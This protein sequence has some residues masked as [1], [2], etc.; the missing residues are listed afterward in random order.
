MSILIKGMA[1]PKNC[2]ECRFSA[3]GYCTAKSINFLDWS[4]VDDQPKPSWCPLV[5]VKPHGRLIDADDLMATIKK[6]K[7][8][9]SYLA[10]LYQEDYQLVGEWVEIAPTVIESEDDDG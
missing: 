6:A 1:I 10:D 8:D 3:G 9:D 2:E 7:D 4:N 5:E